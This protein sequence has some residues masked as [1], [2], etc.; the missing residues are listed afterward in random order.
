VLVFSFLFSISLYRFYEDVNQYI[1]GVFAHLTLAFATFWMFYSLNFSLS[2]SLSLFL[3]LTHLHVNDYVVRWKGNKRV[4]TKVIYSIE[5]TL[6]WCICCI[7]DADRE[8]ET[9][10]KCNTLRR[11]LKW[12][13]FENVKKVAALKVKVKIEN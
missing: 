9:H 2:L 12:G 1:N 5:C 11:W 10:E 3:S 7:R 13:R 4:L 8:H 6:W